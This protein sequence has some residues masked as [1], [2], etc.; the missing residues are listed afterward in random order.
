VGILVVTEVLACRQVSVRHEPALPPTLS[1]VTF[2]LGAGERTALVGL[3]GSG[4][5]TLLTALVGLVPHQGEVEICGQ[6]L[7]R[8]SIAGLRAE[9]GFLFNVPEDQLLFP[10]VVEDVAFGLVRGGCSSSEAFSRATEALDRMGVGELAGHPLH[11]LSHGQKQRVA[12]AGAIVTGPPLMLL[13]EPT[14]GLDP[15]GK[16]SLGE[17]L[18]SLGS[19]QLIAT[20]DLD[21]A[22]RYC[23]RVLL[24]EG[25]TVARDDPDTSFVRRR[26]GMLSS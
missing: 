22:D 12:L 20:H 23:S 5:T 7:T 9:V 11:H 2:S 24:L 8:G 6:A 15:P 13:D 21:F 4:K 1:E 16:A 18:C 19:A 14:A 10:K 25:K 3:N 26:W 17:L